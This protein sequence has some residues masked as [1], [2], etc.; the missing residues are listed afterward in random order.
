MATIILLGVVAELLG[1][2]VDADTDGG[3]IL[4]ALSPAPAHAR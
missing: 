4:A 3:R 2:A 1:V